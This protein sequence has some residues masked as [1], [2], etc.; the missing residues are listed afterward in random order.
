MYLVR[1]IYVSKPTPQYDLQEIDSILAV[2]RAN[3]KKLGITG[4][5]CYHPKFFM[6]LLEGSRERVNNLYNT[7]LQDKRHTLPVI[8]Q[9]KEIISRDFSKW[10]MA[11]VSTKLL[12]E[13]SLFK[14]CVD[15]EFRP[16]DMSGDMAS[17]FLFEV[18]KDRGT[19]LGQRALR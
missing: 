7:I 6:Q 9:Y 10:S 18:A 2:S 1:L 13:E 4:I 5:L 8:L 17:S 12:Q 16:Y 11:Y 15:D 3:N 19:E 14:Y